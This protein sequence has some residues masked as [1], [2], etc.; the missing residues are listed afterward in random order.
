MKKPLKEAVV[1]TDCSLKERGTKI[2]LGASF[3][4]YSIRYRAGST[5]NCRLC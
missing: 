1:T 4:R 2:M 3:C 5:A